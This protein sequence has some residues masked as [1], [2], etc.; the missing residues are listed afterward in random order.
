MTENRITAR[1]FSEDDVAT[2]VSWI[3]N[4][5]INQ[6]MFFELPATVEKTLNW[7]KSIKDNKSRV[8]FTFADAQNEIIAMGGFTAIDPVHRNSEFYVMVH[9]EMHG[10]GYGKKVSK[11]LYNYAFLKFGLNKIYLYTN[12]SNIS[13]Y[14]IYEDSGFQLEG[15]LRAHKWKNGSFQNRRFYGLLQSEWLQTDWKTDEIKYIF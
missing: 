9:P 2:R 13:A 12:D 3:N 5:A 14:K 10:K 1:Y 6:S 15:V 4:P 11:W 7:C 8:D